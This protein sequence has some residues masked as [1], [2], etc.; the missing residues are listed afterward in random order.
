MD[1]SRR[2]PPLFKFRAY[3]SETRRERVRRTLLAGEVYFARPSEFNDPFEARPNFVRSIDDIGKWRAAVRKSALRLFKGSAT[4]RFEAAQRAA[5]LIDPD[6]VDARRRQREQLA[7][8]CAI[9]S[10]AGTREN[11]LLWAHYAADHT[12]LCVHIDHTRPPFGI[13]LPVKYD[14]SYPTIEFPRRHSDAET[15]ERCLFR[16]AKSWE[17]ESEH[18]ICR[19]EFASTISRD[20]GMAWN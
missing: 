4:K 17:Y 19:I 11:P 13:A 6:L 10:M 5:H 14:E 9:F 7:S 16:K 20:L 1:T 3:D 8:Q 15:L 18:R 12:G 2:P